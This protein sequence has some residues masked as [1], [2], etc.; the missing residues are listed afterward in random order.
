MKKDEK[1]GAEIKAHLIGK[2]VETPMS[3]QT[4]Y[5]SK[6]Q[7]ELI[8]DHFR[9]IMYSM[10]LDLSDDSLKGTPDR[11]AKMF[12]D[13]IF[14]GLNYE[15]FPKCTAVENKMKYDEMITIKDINVSSTC[16]HHFVVIDGFAKIAYI[17]NEKVLGLSKFNRIVE[18]FSKRPQIQE[19]LT[20]QIFETLCLILET[21]NVA[22]TIDA[23]HH[24]VKS[25][26][27]ADAN[28]S[29]RTTKLGGLFKEKDSVRLEFLS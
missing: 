18:F 5:D 4:P 13:E 14:Y 22:I 12:V 10:N 21:E 19:R 25:R 7:K 28:S 8:S 26:G 20:A 15:N 23:V 27:V 29:T 9:K 1:L 6:A 2:G 16:E 17:P 11:V 3:N 24:C